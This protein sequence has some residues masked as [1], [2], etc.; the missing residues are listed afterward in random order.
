MLTG[1]MIL[2]LV[3]LAY[4]WGGYPAMLAA[5]AR[6]RNLR[7][8]K[9]EISPRLTVIVAARN[10]EQNI[11][12][13]LRNLCELDYPRE[14]LEI[15]VASDGSTDGTADLVR[16]FAPG[17]VRLLEFHES[18][19]R[20]AVHNDAVKASHGEILVFTDAA[21]RFHSDCLIRLAENFVDKRVGCVSGT[22]AFHNEEASA[23]TEQ[24]G[25]YW[26]YEHWLRTMESR[27]GILCCASGPCMA[28]R[29]ELFRPLTQGSYDVDFITPLDVI[30]SGFLVLQE[31]Q[32]KAA[33]EMFLAPHQELRAQIRMVARNLRGYFDRHCLIGSAARPWFAWSLL[34]HKVLRWMTP[35]FLLLVLLSNT[36][37]MIH[38]RVIVLWLAQLSFYAAPL[39]GY[40]LAERKR[41]PGSLFSAPFAFCLAN[42]GFLLGLI[43]CLRQERITVY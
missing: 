19:G 24:R 25:L 41:R 8:K 23:V 12:H 5:L 30:E 18:R 43:K 9:A 40:L 10:E 3:T 7:I 29:R 36:V 16:E 42:L 4:T 35:L 31:A 28:V 6:F 13:R 22:I 20:A 26:R 14:C 32:A 11:A 37:L 1:I 17:W 34:S 15:I 38:G 21:T 39:A 27:C 33:D 2:G